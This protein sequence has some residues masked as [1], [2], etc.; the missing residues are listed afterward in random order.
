LISNFLFLK[1]TMICFVVSLLLFLFVDN[2]SASSLP[3][4][5]QS[6]LRELFNEVYNFGYRDRL[7]SA[8]D[9]LGNSLTVCRP[10]GLQYSY[11]DQFNTPR[12]DT[13]P[14]IK[15]DDTNSTVVAIDLAAGPVAA[16]GTVS[17]SKANFDQW[18][19]AL[20]DLQRLNF[21][22]GGSLFADR[23]VGN[24]SATLKAL[25]KLVNCTLPP[26]GSS[27]ICCVTGTSPHIP[28]TSPCLASFVSRLN[29]GAP[30]DQ[31]TN[32]CSNRIRDIGET[33]T[34]CGGPCPACTAS[35]EA[36]SCFNGIL[37]GLETGVDCGGGCV[38]CCENGVLDPD[39]D[40]IDCN[41]RG[42]SCRNCRRECRANACNTYTSSNCGIVNVCTREKAEM[43]GAPDCP[44][45]SC[46]NLYFGWFERACRM[47]EL[48]GICT[49]TTSSTGSCRNSAP[50][51]TECMT[52]GRVA[53][54]DVFV[55][56]VACQ[57]PD[58]CQKGTVRATGSTLATVCKVAGESCGTDLACNRQG[59]CVTKP[60]CGA[61]ERYTGTGCAPACTSFPC[62]N[63]ICVDASDTDQC[64]SKVATASTGT[65]STFAS[66]KGRCF[67]STSCAVSCAGSRVAVTCDT[68]CGKPVN[69]CEVNSTIGT[70]GPNDVCLV[71]G[72]VCPAGNCLLGGK[73]RA[74]KPIALFLTRTAANATSSSAL[75]RDR[76]SMLAGAY[77]ISMP[78]VA[79]TDDDNW[80]T[81]RLYVDEPASTTRKRANSDEFKK[82]LIAEES[83]HGW[84]ARETRPTTTPGASTTTPSGSGGPV[85][86]TTTSNSG[87]SGG[88]SND[89]SGTPQ[90][91][92]A[93]TSVVA[94]GSSSTTSGDA[95]DDGAVDDN[96]SGEFPVGAV[97]GGIAGGLC[98]IVLI[99]AVI[100]LVR[101]R[102]N[103][104]PNSLSTIGTDDTAPTDSAALFFSEGDEPLQLKDSAKTSIYASATALVPS[105]V[106][107][108]GKAPQIGTL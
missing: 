98:L 75:L 42:G 33:G 27:A 21:D 97:V 35:T 38:S 46:S 31:C 37:D 105:S 16:A 56:D 19:L 72:S 54:T 78:A 55:C 70:I 39:E 53:S 7:E 4:A 108:Y 8:L 32:C 43:C 88:S 6:A 107:E 85:S 83:I 10:N 96:E 41:D 5:Q 87:G 82:L 28:P 65:C 44:F 15:C 57:R 20:T 60:T 34:D 51:Q 17:L 66:A 89:V 91:S 90:G 86:G 11:R 79:D 69:P 64:V 45:R 2:S 24:L 95:T 14:A 23:A 13:F 49:T 62:D 48:T 52:I 106:G 25:T 104:H 100:L 36:N 68:G 93:S 50:N 102:K 67:N 71:D 22:N 101:R 26:Q 29:G 47:F 80:K 103:D 92:G 3:S 76:V 9:S 99:A 18:F 94:G 84:Q 61:C 58:T 81:L 1:K 63:D 30:Q 12:I 74:A 73:C 59:R 77:L 40:D